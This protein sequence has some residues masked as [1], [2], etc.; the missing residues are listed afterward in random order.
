MKAM[1][2]N[3][4]LHSIKKT[5]SLGKKDD[6]EERMKEKYN[7]VNNITTKALSVPT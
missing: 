4:K 5:A 7:L 6:I 2:Q 3:V 1:V